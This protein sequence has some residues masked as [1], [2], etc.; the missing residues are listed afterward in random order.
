MIGGEIEL[1][2][3]TC[4]E[5]HW[6]LCDN[7]NWVYVGPMHWFQKISVPTFFFLN[8]FWSRLTIGVQIVGYGELV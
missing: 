5:T 4:W 3:E 6:E 7:T 2:L 1:V 8:H